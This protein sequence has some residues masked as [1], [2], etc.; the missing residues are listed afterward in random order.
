MRP[1]GVGANNTGAVAAPPAVWRIV[2]RSPLVQGSY[3]GLRHKVR[4]KAIIRERGFVCHSNSPIWNL[5]LRQ[6][7]EIREL[8]VQPTLTWVVRF[9]LPE[10]DSGNEGNKG[11]IW[12]A[13]SGPLI[14][15][16]GAWER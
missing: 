2:G 7:F 5:L 8:K 14:D 13:P 15:L 3:P 9:H 4:H 6:V 12:F 16:I 10:A 1:S 11:G